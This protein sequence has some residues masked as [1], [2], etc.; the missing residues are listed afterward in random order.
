MR[1]PW[2][3]LEEAFEQCHALTGE[4]RRAYLNDLAKQDTE[5][6]LELRKLLEADDLAAADSFFEPGALQAAS[7][8]KDHFVGKQIGTFTI[9]DMIGEGGMGAVYRAEQTRPFHRLAAIKVIW[10]SHTN[11]HLLR[12]FDVEVQTL[13]RL[14][15]PNIA[16]VYFSGV[17]DN[18]LP[19]FCM[20][21]IDGRP[22]DVYCRENSLGVADRLTLFAEICRAVHFAHQRGVIHRDIKP[23]NILI[24][25]VDGRPQVKMIDFGIAKAVQ[26][27]KQIEHSF[28]VT[29]T[30]LTIPGMAVGTLGYMSPEQTLVSDQDVD[31]R[32]DVYALGVVLYELLVGDL[33]ISRQTISEKSWDQIFKAI[34]D[35][36]PAIPSQ[37]VLS[38]EGEPHGEIGLGKAALSKKYRGDI[39]WMVM[40]ALAKEPDRRYESALAFAEDCERHL[41]NEP[42]LACPPSL[43]YLISRFV[44]RNKGLSAGLAVVL[45]ALLVGLIGLGAG[46]Y[47]AKQAEKRM[48]KEIETANT[49]IDVLEEFIVSVTPSKE[50]ADVKMMDR[51]NKFAPTIQELGLSDAIRGK[52]HFVIGKA[53]FA[54]GSY[55]DA[56]YHFSSAEI[57]LKKANG[58]TIFESSKEAQAI[59]EGLGE[60]ERKSSFTREGQEISSDLVVNYYNSIFM[61]YR[62]TDLSIESARRIELVRSEK[63]L[64]LSEDVHSRYHKQSGVLR[65]RFFRA[66]AIFYQYQCDYRKAIGYFVASNRLLQ[67][68]GVVNK[69]FVDNCIDLSVVFNQE[70]N[71]EN[72]EYYINKAQ[73]LSLKAYG[74]KSDK[75]FRVFV[76]NIY[77][78]IERGDY[79]EALDL[80]MG[81]LNY[82]SYMESI[83]DDKNLMYLLRLAEVASSRSG[84]QDAFLEFIESFNEAF[85]GS[86]MD[87]YGSLIRNGTYGSALYNAGKKDASLSLLLIAY[88]FAN[89]IGHYRPQLSAEYA[90]N[91]SFGF[92]ELGDFR[93]A[94]DWGCV[95]ISHLERIIC[96]VD[97]SLLMDCKIQWVKSLVESDYPEGV[98]ELDNVIREVRRDFGENHEKAVS[99]EAYKDAM[100][101]RLKVKGHTLMN[102]K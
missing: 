91:L 3:K 2:E 95:A 59:I 5:L 1:V 85:L 26:D 31:L 39:D 6:F 72:A 94:T 90:L 19:Y 100:D 23:A 27:D 70:G 18:G 53:Y 64:K 78:L 83:G 93:E 12:R 77:N 13:A 16:S 61:F 25:E 14:N 41:T 24:A 74:K 65:A 92:Y 8:L 34:R 84:N 36:T 54:I 22:L 44:K 29:A 11:E 88:G 56:D 68:E 58:H 9:K 73:M 20:E 87:Y 80:G 51:L 55:P 30:L 101:E 82:A 50:G 96:D 66:K 63:F 62:Y 4:P 76:F 81:I 60:I 97:V 79:E 46:Y 98:E 86:K 35:K 37:A 17:T 49:T 89:E 40:K 15:H 28:Q 75:T 67:S 7:L 71:I 38:V 99:L 43:G 32:T 57:L 42:V 33:P 10:A 69:A 102:S 52:L 45:V 48:E 47:Q 21:L